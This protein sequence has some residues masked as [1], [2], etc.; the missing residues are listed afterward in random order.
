MKIE[1]LHKA[2]LTAICQTISDSADSVYMAKYTEDD[3]HIEA[4]LNFEHSSSYERLQELSGIL[5]RYGFIIGK[6][7]FGEPTEIHVV[8][9]IQDCRFKTAIAEACAIFEIFADDDQTIKDLENLD[10][11]GQIIAC[12]MKHKEVL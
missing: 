2:V 1:E 12:A 6:I 8:S 10:S 5:C 3:R 11:V 9:W 4:V 7:Y